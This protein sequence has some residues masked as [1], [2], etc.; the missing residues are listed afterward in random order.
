MKNNIS[1]PNDLFFK[2]N[3]KNLAIAKDFL[4][5]HLPEDIQK[6]L[7]FN[8]L[9]A[10]D[11]EFV[12]PEL[13]KLQSDFVYSC[14]IDNQESYVY[15]LVEHQSSADSLMA[16][17]KLQYNVALMDDHLKKGNTKLPVIIS[18]CLYHGKKSPY[19]YSSDIYDCFEDS[20]LAREHMFK[21]F[22]LID[23]TVMED[24]EI[25]GHGLASFMELLFKHHLDKRLV[26][27]LK[28]LHKDNKLAKYLNI[29]GDSNYAMLVLKY[30]MNVGDDSTADAGEIIDIFAGALPN[31]RSDFMTFAQ[32]LREE[33]IE[34]GIE[35]GILKG[36]QE[37][38]LEGM[39]KGV[40]DVAKNMLSKGFSD[41]QIIEITGIDKNT[42]NNIKNH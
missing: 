19:P 18:L 2:A 38:I 30:L 28:K 33:G 4:K 5:V 15:F 7:D 36:K 29:S 34:K 6:R 17:R 14:L 21:P 10:T 8:S 20:K 11:K 24:S 25:E 9:K 37:G 41:D 35:K 31:Q 13:K 16:F 40:L 12:T 32:R 1:T 39:Q 26:E 23:L 22:K 3:F 42:L 27:Y